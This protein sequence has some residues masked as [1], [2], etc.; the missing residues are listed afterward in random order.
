MRGVGEPIHWYDSCAADGVVLDATYDKGIDAAMRRF[1][2]A[3]RNRV[4]H[5]PAPL[6][7]RQD[8]EGD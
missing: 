7:T 4:I 5:A 2:A 8:E 3:G 6:L 1:A